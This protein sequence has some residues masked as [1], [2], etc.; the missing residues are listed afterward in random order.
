MPE[1]KPF[2]RPWRRF[3]RFS[4]RGTIGIVLIIG[5][6]LGW[7][8]RSARIQ[9]NA[10]ASVKRAGR[11]ILYERN[12]NM[13]EGM[14]LRDRWPI[15]PKWLVDSLGIDYFSN[16]DGVVLRNTGTDK[17]LMAIACLR[18]LRFLNL[19]NSPITDGGL[20]KLSGLTN[21]T[22][23]RLHGTRISDV[24]LSHL[25]GLTRFWELFLVDTR[26]TDAGL[27]HLR[28]LSSL[29]RCVFPG[30]SPITVSKNSR[31]ICQK[32][33]SSVGFRMLPMFDNRTSNGRGTSDRSRRLVVVRNATSRPR[34]SLARGRH[35]QSSR[36][37]LASPA[38]IP[39]PALQRGGA[40][41]CCA[42]DRRRAWLDPAERTNPA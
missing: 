15:P 6:W 31:R 32:R 7:F 4:V 26:V 11:T 24:G 34:P 21:L 8:V 12:M 10:V 13:D 35:E 37:C 20:K 5:V 36:T 19:G 16:V 28:C 40:D 18:H 27:G 33:R 14:W 30:V 41:R 2:S 9:R 17:D 3:L 1:H 42:R 38:K 39:V 29:T 25:E 23:L 22:Q